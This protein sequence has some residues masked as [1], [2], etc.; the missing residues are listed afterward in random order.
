[1]SKKEDLLNLIYMSLEDIGV[2]QTKEG[3]LFSNALHY[4]KPIVNAA[5]A[6]EPAAHALES[7]SKATKPGILKSTFNSAANAFGTSKKFIHPV[8]STIGAFGGAELDQLTTPEAHEAINND[9]NS[10]WF[11]KSITNN[12]PDAGG[13][14]KYIGAGLPTA[15]S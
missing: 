13:N 9:P 7:S 1:M 6:V 12:I 8:E 10:S 15:R 3:G 14:Y 2:V 11:A 5:H 4:F